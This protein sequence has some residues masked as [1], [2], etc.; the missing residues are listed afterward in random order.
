MEIIIIIS[1][2]IQTTRNDWIF[3]DIDP[4]VDN[5]RRKFILE[6]SFLF[7]RAKLELVAAME[8]WVQNL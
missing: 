1:W 4:I 7:H 5:C 8:V 3:K 6:V 2:S